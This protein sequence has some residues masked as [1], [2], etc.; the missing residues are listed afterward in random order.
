MRRWR[1][2]PVLLLGVVPGLATSCPVL[3][4]PMLYGV[5]GSGG[6]PSSLYTIN[7][8]T[9]ATTL[10]GAT[11]T[12][13]VTGIDFDPITGTLYGVRSDVFGSG[14]TQLLT[15]YSGTVAAAV[16]GTTSYRIPDITITRN[17]VLRGWSDTD[18]TSSFFDNPVEINKATGVTSHTVSGLDTNGTGVA[19][20]DEANLYVTSRVALY[21]VNVT[22]GA[23]HYYLADLVQTRFSKICPAAI[24]S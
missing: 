4:V 1:F 18:A 16:V 14:E 13:H 6:S 2:N 9:G 22:T 12:N 23:K 3:A 15:L 8:L 10:V 21:S 17:G 19:V 5:T 24:F 11:G 20:L 7:P